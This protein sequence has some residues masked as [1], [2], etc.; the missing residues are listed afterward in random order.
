MLTECLLWFRHCSKYSYVLLHLILTVT[1]G[2]NTE[3]ERLSHLLKVR[4]PGNVTMGMLTSKPW[5][6][7]WLTSSNSPRY[8]SV[9]MIKTHPQ[10]SASR[11]P[12]R[13]QRW[14]ASKMHWDTNDRGRGGKSNSPSQSGGKMRIRSESLGTSRRLWAPL[15]A[16][17][18][19]A[20]STSGDKEKV[21]A[22]FPSHPPELRERRNLMG[23]GSLLHPQAL[24]QCQVHCG[25]SRKHLLLSE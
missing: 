9:R 1:L 10:N 17:W 13:N 21:P 5:R 3:W 25:G 22:F 8:T 15:W 23:S 18:L 2:G 6:S 14:V 16:P 24:P 7:T 20:E 12:H 19:S 11:K 4:S